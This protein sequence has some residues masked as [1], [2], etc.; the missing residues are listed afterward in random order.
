M[1]VLFQFSPFYFIVEI[2]GSLSVK[3]FGIGLFSVRVKL[4]LEGPTPYRAKG[5]GKI[6][7]LF[8]SFKARFDITWGEQKDTTLPPVE[9]FPLI[10]T[11]IR[12]LQNWKVKVPEGN[13]LL[14]SF[15]KLEEEE[16]LVLHPVGVLQISQRKLPLGIKIDK[17]GNQKPSDANKFDLSLEPNGLDKKGTLKEQFAIGQFIEMDNSNKLS[18]KDFEKEES[19]LELSITGNQRKTGYAAIRT[20]RY[21]Q[22]IIDT[23]FRRVVFFLVSWIGS[24]FSHFL[25]GNA[26]SRATISNAQQKKLQPFEDKITISNESFTVAF[27]SNNSPLNNESVAFESQARALDYMNAKIEEDPNLAESIHVIPQ[28]EMNTFV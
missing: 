1:D 27:N 6:K 24:L 7:I 8:F 20:V 19:G 9:V 15:R 21:E 11:E 14:V 26:V 4:S 16:K 2:S 5:Y 10:E 25:R 18:R 13:N 12:N 23:Q 22:I 17:L 3:V 28:T